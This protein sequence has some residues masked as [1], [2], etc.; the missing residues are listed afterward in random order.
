MTAA[1]FTGDKYRVSIQISKFALPM[2]HIFL[3]LVLT[4]E[5]FRHHLHLATLAAQLTNALTRSATFLL[6]PLREAPAWQTFEGLITSSLTPD[7]LQVV[8]AVLIMVRHRITP[9]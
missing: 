4:I 3:A 1:W 9:C 8:V 5:H 6:Q 2:M 7:A